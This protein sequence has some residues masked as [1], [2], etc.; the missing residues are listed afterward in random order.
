MWTLMVCVG[1]FWPSCGQI[2]MADHPTEAAC[3]AAAKQYLEINE[4]PKWIICKP[5]EPRK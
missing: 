2:L 4:K 5:K 3:W 1:Y